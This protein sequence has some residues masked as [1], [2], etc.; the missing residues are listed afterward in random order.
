MSPSL[1]QLPEV[2]DLEM[3]QAAIHLKERRK[4]DTYFLATGPYR[5]ELYKKH[6]QFFAAGRTYRQRGFVAGN[7]T[8][9]TD[10]GAFEMTLH[11]TGEY[12]AWWEGRRFNKAIKAWACGEN[13]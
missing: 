8:G 11:L 12:P 10:A 13:S 1:S 2:L 9:K 6:L 4:I 7:R 5:R 3:V